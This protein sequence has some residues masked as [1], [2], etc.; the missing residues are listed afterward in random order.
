MTT[1]TK[2]KTI[3]KK[4]LINFISLNKK[5]APAEVRQV[6]QTFLDQ[7]TQHLSRGERIE[8]RD[9]GIFEVVMR[10]QKIGRNPKNASQPVIIPSHLA[11]KFTPS[12][13]MRSEVEEEGK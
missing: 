12:K 2:K 1:N 13:K 9:F 5:I 11:V 3:T 4:D 7:L 10:K 6:I 8:F